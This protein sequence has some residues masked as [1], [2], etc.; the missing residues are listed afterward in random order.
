MNAVIG[1]N[2]GERAGLWSEILPGLWQGGT[3]DG[4]WIDSGKRR[5]H[6]TKFDFDSVYTFFGA[7]N[8]ADY[9]VHETRFAFYD[10]DMSDFDVEA[11]LLPIVE[12]AHN[13]WV[14]GRK[15][16]IRCQ[17]GLNRSGLVM[18]LVLMRA[19]RDARA[20][21]DLIRE[22]RCDAAL[23]NSTFEHWLLSAGSTPTF[24]LLLAG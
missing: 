20:A 23:C 2:N 10:G 13:D 1:E 14:S 15:V 11:D 18:A 21:I 4:D 19:G 3:D 24:Q 16:L 5:G 12:K 8:P 17:A 22:K 6:V 9:G 7:A